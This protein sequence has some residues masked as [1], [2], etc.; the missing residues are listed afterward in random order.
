MY[1][2]CNITCLFFYEGLSIIQKAIVPVFAVTGPYLQLYNNNIVNHLDG[3]N[4]AT[5]ELFDN[6]RNLLSVI[7]TAFEVERERERERER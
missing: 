2:V 4:A 5:A 3:T 1:F 6:S 7:E